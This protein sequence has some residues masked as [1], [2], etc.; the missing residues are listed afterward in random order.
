MA[1]SNAVTWPEVCTLT[2]V[3]GE[4][5]VRRRAPSSSPSLSQQLPVVIYLR[6]KSDTELDHKKDP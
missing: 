6:A 5:E 1:R 3:I 4:G 2:A